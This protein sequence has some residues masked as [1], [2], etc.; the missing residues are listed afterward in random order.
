M[1][2]DATLSQVPDS[3]AGIASTPDIAYHAVKHA[4]E[5]NVAPSQCESC[6]EALYWIGFGAGRLDYSCPFCGNVARSDFEWPDTLG[7]AGA[8]IPANLEAAELY[9]AYLTVAGV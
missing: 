5:H 2:N 1:S 4:I 8:W 9:G 7:S 6:G 3:V